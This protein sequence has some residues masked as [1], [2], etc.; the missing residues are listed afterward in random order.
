MAN[1]LVDIYNGQPAA[2]NT[3]LYTAPANTIV[4]ILAASVVND[5]TVAKYISF[6]RVPSG[7]SVSDANIIIN[8]KLVGSKESVPLWELV[9]QVLEAGDFLSAIA[10]TASQLTTHI[11]GIAIV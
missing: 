6:H 2:S 1:T 10:E 11:S 8:Q 5:T 7:G 9:G 4:K 3:T